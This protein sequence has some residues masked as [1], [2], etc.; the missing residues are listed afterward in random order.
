VINEMRAGDMFGELALVTDQPRSTGAIAREAS[1]VISIPRA[2]FLAELERDPSLMRRVLKTTAERLQTSS[3][4]ESALAFF[5]APTRLA[6][7]LLQMDQQAND[8]G[9]IICSQ[10]E[11]AQRVG[12]TRQT[13]AKTLGQWRRAGWLLTGRGKIV[14]LNRAALHRQAAE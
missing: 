13:V 9:Y 10:E 6:R 12:L 4:R 3:E 7:T 1:Q 5:D 14:L 8:Q 2:S 11:L